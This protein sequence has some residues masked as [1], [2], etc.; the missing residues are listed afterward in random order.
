MCCNGTE[1]DDGLHDDHFHGHDLVEE[2]E[3][4]FERD[5]GLGDDHFHGATGHQR[6]PDKWRI[7]PRIRFSPLD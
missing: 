1:R 7:K 4:D 5:D 3:E 6:A 2:P